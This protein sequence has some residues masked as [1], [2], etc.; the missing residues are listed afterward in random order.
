MERSG[1]AVNNDPLFP[2]I[3]SCVLFI[4]FALFLL[5]L[6][7]LRSR[8]Y[9]HGPNYSFLFWVFLYCLVMGVGLIRRK[10]WAVILIF[11]PGI[12]L[13]ANFT[14]ILKGDISTLS[15][16]AYYVFGVL[17]I[18]ILLIWI[19]ALLLRSWKELQW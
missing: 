19:P 10:K 16:L 8:I 15:A 12:S 4:A 6:V 5:L 14:Y 13:L 9:Y 1:R 17:I 7:N 3:G 11:L 18:A 2:A